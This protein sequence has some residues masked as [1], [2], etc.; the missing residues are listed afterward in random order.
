[1]IE[2]KRLSWLVALGVSLRGLAARAGLSQEL[3]PRAYWPAP[4]GTRLAVFGYSYTAGDILTD[5]SL[6]IAG[7]DSRINSLVVGYLRTLNLFGRTS[8]LVINVP[9]A[10]GSTKG[11]LEGQGAKREYS[12][13]G[14]LTVTLSINFLGAP[15][16]TMEGLQELRRKP[17][18]IFG[19]SLKVL[20]PNGKYDPDRLFNV[21]SNRWAVKGD[22]GYILPLKPKWL[23]ELDLGM[24]VSEDNDEFLGVIRKQDPIATGQLHLIKRFQP[25]FWASLDLNYYTGGRSTIDGNKAGDLQRN[26]RL[27]G[28]IVVPIR[29]GHSIK[30]GYSTGVVTESGGDF[31]QFLVSYQT[32][33]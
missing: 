31:N 18:S 26:S 12:G 24:W 32:L 15:T 1:M 22:L 6:P 9:F 5:P 17:R 10:S 29:K 2:S 21:G 8:N 14:D 23:L 30:V 13:L 11:L 20:V 7:V 16:M 28:T 27:G 4:R 33:F 25:G 3:T 19:G